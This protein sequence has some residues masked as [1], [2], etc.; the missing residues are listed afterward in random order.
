MYVG[1]DKT[2][3]DDYKETKKKLMT[4]IKPT[5]DQIKKEKDFTSALIKK[6]KEMPGSHIDVVLAGS[7]A[8]GTNLKETKDFDIFVL[9]PKDLKKEDFTREALD[10]GQS[11]FKGYFSEK[12]YSEHPYVR[13]VIDGYKIDLVPAY[14]I[15]ST[16]NMISSVDRTP[17]HLEYLL[18]NLKDSQKDD[19]RLLKYFLKYIGCYGADPQ[20]QGF[21][22]YLCELLILYYGDFIKT[23]EKVGNWQTPVRIVLNQED[24]DYL[25]P[26][27][28]AFVVID[29]VDKNRNV[30]SAV[31]LTQLSRFIAASRAFL[32]N[33]TTEF[34]SKNPK[35]QTYHQL[36][37][38][39]N[40]V[41]LVAIEFEVKDMLKDIVWSKLRKLSTKLNNYLDTQK[42]T[43][44]K[45]NIYYEEKD[46]YAYIYLMLD[47]LSQPKLERTTGPYVSD[48]TNSQK[49]IDNSKAI[50]GPY[51]KDDR[52]Y[53]VKARRFTDARDLIQDFSQNNFDLKS[54]IFL[55]QEIIK[56]YTKNTK[57]LSYFTDFFFPREN[58]L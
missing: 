24:I 25:A 41:P 26:F 56:L 43:V 42:F 50:Y 58:F 46:E 2:R 9:Y 5:D 14:K 17:F 18:K 48:M 37:T 53:C 16:E 1:I 22:G 20:Y 23:I 57:V 21:S 38:W 31:S 39:V 3:I 12:V 35:E 27:N 13:G 32:H 33:P 49:F 28:D 51:V 19:I 47:S 44:L 8:R 4:V 6:I 40:N 10:L 54:Q 52:W 36:V 11:F 15:E 45:S 55:E 29:P 7:S 30:A 34:F